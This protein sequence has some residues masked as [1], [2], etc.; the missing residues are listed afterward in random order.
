MDQAPLEYHTDMAWMDI[1]IR[2]EGQGDSFD[3]R[4]CMENLHNFCEDVQIEGE[5]CSGQ[6]RALI[7]M[8]MKLE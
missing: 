1:K 5:C 2:A 4:F 7:S 8:I 3:G 6:E